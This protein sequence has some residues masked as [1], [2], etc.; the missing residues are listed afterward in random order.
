MKI[1]IAAD[2]HIGANKFGT[3]ENKLGIRL[4]D[5]TAKGIRDHDGQL[6]HHPINPNYHEFNPIDSETSEVK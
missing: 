5:P 3:D 6:I 4:D 2:L 1:L